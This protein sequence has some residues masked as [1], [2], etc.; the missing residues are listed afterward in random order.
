MEPADVID[1]FKEFLYLAE[2]K[3]GTVS[4]ETASVILACKYNTHNKSD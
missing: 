1:E 4:G 2:N 3:Y